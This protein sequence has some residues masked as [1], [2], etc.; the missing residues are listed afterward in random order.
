MQGEGDGAAG[1][2]AEPRVGPIGA[3]A[4]GVNPFHIEDEKGA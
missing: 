3:F 4:L 2:H 1:R